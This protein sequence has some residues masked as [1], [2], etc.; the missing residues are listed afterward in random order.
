MGNIIKKFENFDQSRVDRILDKISKSGIESLSRQEKEYLASTFGDK[1]S[2][3][4]SKKSSLTQNK[5]EK[6]TKY[7]VTKGEDSLEESNDIPD[8]FESEKVK[9]SLEKPYTIGVLNWNGDGG[10]PIGIN[11]YVEI[12][13]PFTRYFN[14]DY[15]ATEYIKFEDGTTYW[16]CWS[17]PMEPQ[18]FD[19]LDID[20]FYFEDEDDRDKLRSFYQELRSINTSEIIG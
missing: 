5:K 19:K 16:C 14:S 10:E 2:K 15:D 4:D 1:D 7:K 18:S 6:T 17:T 3:K 11:C 12:Y 8:F 9:C 20:D 13:E